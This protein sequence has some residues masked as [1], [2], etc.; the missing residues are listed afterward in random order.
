MVVCRILQNFNGSRAL[1]ITPNLD[2]VQGLQS[3]VCKLGMDV[4][5]P[6]IRNGRAGVDLSA[7]RP[8]RDIIF[9][10]SDVDFTTIFGPDG[11]NKFL[12]VPVIGLV[13][14]EAPSRLKNLIVV[15][16]T[17]FLRKPVNGAA[18]YTALFLGVNQFLIRNNLETKLE[19]LE[20]RRRGRRWVV[21]AIV[22]LM[23]EMDIDDDE[24]HAKLRRESMKLRMT[25]EDY[26]ETIVRP[27]LAVNELEDRKKLG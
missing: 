14:V 23:R 25:I 18:A 7:L 12:P 26:C 15:G 16:A 13:G 27:Y 5:F 20:R 10:D 21:K 11:N 8:E 3:T 22:S 1:V 19:D 6:E 4:N 17:E 9:L 24:A 2:A